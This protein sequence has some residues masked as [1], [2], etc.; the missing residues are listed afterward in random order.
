ML[1]LF[2]L[3]LYPGSYLPPSASHSSSPENYLLSACFIGEAH[4]ISY[5]PLKCINNIRSVP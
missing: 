2:F 3:P 5:L 1:L 4:V